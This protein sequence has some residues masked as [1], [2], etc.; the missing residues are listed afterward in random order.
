[1]SQRSERVAKNTGFMFIRMFLLMFIGLFTS[2]EVLRILGVDDYGIYNLVGTI[3][4]MFTF[5]QSALNNATTRFITYD[6]GSGIESNLKRTFSM[7][8]NTEVIL[9]LIILLLSECIGPWFIE[10]KLNIPQN[11]INAAQIVFQISLINFLLRILLTPFN[12]TIIAH[13][14]M[15]FFAYISILEALGQLAIVYML[16]IISFDKLIVYASLQ[17]GVTILMFLGMFIYCW[18]NFSE[19]HYSFYWDNRLLKQLSKYSGWSLLVNMVDIAVIQSISIFFNIFQGV[20][21][22]AALGVANQVNAKLNQ[23]VNNF[24][25]SYN[26]QIIKSYAGKDKTYFM[27]LIFSTSKISFFLFF[28]VSFPILLNINFILQL[29]LHTVPEDTNLFIYCIIAYSLLDSFSQ[30]LW[31]SVHATGNLKVHQILMGSIKLLNIPISFL[32]L[33]LG[34]PVITVLII[35]AIL[36]LICCIVRIWWLSI[37]IKLDINSYLN[38][39]ILKIIFVSIISTLIPIILFLI[40]SDGLISLIFSIVCFYPIYFTTIYKLALNEQEKH[41]LNQFITKAK[42]RFIR[43]SASYNR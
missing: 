2:R 25:Q 33:K 38:D 41:L 3:V 30:P 17:V 10:H 24:S 34:Y 9:A 11:R 23:F 6:L 39:V 22:N 35:Y 40:I 27:R 15:N 20:A 8:L 31:T 26:P 32:F 4:V 29:W 12:S 7:S 28:G 19:T 37:L 14:K 5:L 13:E 1:M 42:N 16:T 43:N 21:A 18:K 36:N